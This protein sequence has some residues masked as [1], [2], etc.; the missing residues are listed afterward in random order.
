[1]PVDK[2]TLTSSILAVPPLTSEQLEKIISRRGWGDTVK[3]SPFNCV[4][5]NIDRF[6]SQAFICNPDTFDSPGEHW[7]VRFY[8]SSG[9]MIEISIHSE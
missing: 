7:Y 9:A 1:M 4:P 2:Y 3:V 5:Q 6:R 8:P